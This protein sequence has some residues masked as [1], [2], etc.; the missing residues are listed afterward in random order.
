MKTINSM[1]FPEDLQWTTEEQ[2]AQA[3][4]QLFH[5]AN[6]RCDGFREWYLKRIAVKK[7][8]A[9]STRL[10]AIMSTTMAGIIP[11]LSTLPMFAQ[12]E[13]LHAAW[14]SVALAVAALLVALDKFA[15]Y[16]S[17]WIRYTLTEQK[18]RQRQQQFCF[19]WQRIKVLNTTDKPLEEVH[20]FL[21]DTQSLVH[22]ETQQ[23]AKEFQQ[24]LSQWEKS[25][26][27]SPTRK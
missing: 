10:G 15:G 20:Q 19:D 16:T 26:M 7:R 27:A 1:G 8:A 24:H 22:E 23:W 21:T 18:L 13:W 5:Y 25:G 2:S 3:L 12:S 17:G 6:R 4:S 11:M 14:S 9:L